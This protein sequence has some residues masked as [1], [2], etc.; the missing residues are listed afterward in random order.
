MEYSVCEP[1]NK[2]Q[3]NVE[4]MQHEKTIKNDTAKDT[5]NENE[6]KDNIFLDESDSEKVIK[7]FNKKETETKKEES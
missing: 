5:E 7:S 3:E 6:E 2:T 1:I 4:K